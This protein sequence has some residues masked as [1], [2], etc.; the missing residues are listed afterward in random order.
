MST[1]YS[2]HHH[3]ESYT[4]LPL[5]EYKLCFVLHQKSANTYVKT[6][7]KKA[8]GKKFIDKRI[9][10]WDWEFLY[11]WEIPE[12]YYTVSIV[13]DPVERVKSLYADKFLGKGVAKD[14]A[15]IGY[16]HDMSFEEYT[17]LVCNQADR[18]I[19]KHLRQQ[20]FSMYHNG[21]RI[22]DKIFKV[23]TVDWDNFAEN[24]F[25][26]TGLYLDTSEAPVNQGKDRNKQKVE[27]MM[28]PEILDKLLI[29]YQDDINLLGYFKWYQNKE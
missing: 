25:E 13:R 16:R 29:R 10:N 23:E 27:K 4:I 21:K 26:K 20:T 3:R 11:P 18:V 1:Q 28:T 12:D 24:I 9:L 19:E 14:L 7:I 17:T 8:Q 22:V 5:H 6:L 15:D 2:V